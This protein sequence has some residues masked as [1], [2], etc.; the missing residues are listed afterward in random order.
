M[1]AGKLAQLGHKFDVACSFKNIEH[2]N[3]DIK[4]VYSVSEIIS[5][6]GV[7]ICSTCN[8]RDSSP[9]SL[10]P[11][12]KFHVREYLLDEFK[13][14]LKQAFTEVEIF[15]VKRSPRLDFYRKLKKTGILNFI[16]NN[17]NPVKNY[18]NN[19]NTED[20]IITKRNLESALD[21]IAVC[22]K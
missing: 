17:I 2:I 12:N 16:Q 18:Y 14:L 3:D 5:E 20:F 22:R 4:Y 1:D 13:L 9:G 8:R 21:F 10:A 6:R 19:I 11:L 15:G 7:F